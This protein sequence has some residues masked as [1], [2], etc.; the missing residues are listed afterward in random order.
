VIVA[1]KEGA[2]KMSKSLLV[3]LGAAAGVALMS[4]SA[5]AAFSIN[6]DALQNDELVNNFYNG[7][8]GSLG[9]G[10]GP[11]YGVTFTNAYVLNE[12]DNNE[13]EL[14]TP[15]NSITFLSGS[16]SIMDVAAGFTTGFSFNYSAPYYGGDVTVWSGLDGTGTQLA[17]LSLPTT[18]AG[19]DP[20]CGGHEYCPDVPFGV[21]FS[22][23]AQS[24]NFSGSADYIVFDDITV[25][26]GTV[27]TGG[28]PEPSTWAMMMVGFA[29]LGFAGWRKARPVTSI[30]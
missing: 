11:N 1:A 5:H 29:G 26:S 18:P 27:I 12:Y 6:F 10:P 13:G 17:N 24:V 2:G 22:G 21:L 20:G 16:G 3:L 9:S 7:G 28:V 8:F 14:V 23:I 30:A 19:V 4:A 15:P 25:G